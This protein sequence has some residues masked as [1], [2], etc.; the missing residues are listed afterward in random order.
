MTGNLLLKGMLAGL[1]AG[2]IAFGFA[3][4]F[5][6]PQV[7]I[8]IAFEEQ[9]AAAEAPAATTETAAHAE[10]EGVSR[11]TQAGIGLFTGVMTYSIAMGGIFSLVF[12]GLYGRVG[13]LSPRA[14]SAVLGVAVF[15]AIV[16]VPDLK[17][18]PNPPAVGNP[19]T[20]G[21]RTQLYFVTL[22]ASIVGMALAFAL[23]RNL[24][25]KLG[26]WNGAIAAG[27]AYVVFIAI[28]LKL[29]PAINE[30][31]ENFPSLGLY[32]FRIATIG[33]QA[34]IWTVLALAFGYLAERQLSQSGLY[35]RPLATVR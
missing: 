11:E 31:P 1:I 4:V 5:G 14:L 29:L 6:E 19:E 24:A 20:I 3:R 12:A 34:T 18:P 27:L 30:V 15:L 10:P 13:T 16:I 26:T 28:V 2:L 17:Y 35:R 21:V 22:I 33:L 7:E 23:A 8:A 9:M 25:A 32:E